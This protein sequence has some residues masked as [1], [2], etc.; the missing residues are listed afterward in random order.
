M[1]EREMWKMLHL[2]YTAPPG[3]QPGLSLGELISAGLNC[4]EDTYDPLLKSDAVLRN[5][6]RFSLSTAASAILRSCVVANRKRQGVDVWVDYP[7]AFVIMP[8]SKD[9][10]NKV[11]EGLIKPALAGADLEYVRGDTSP[12][13]SELT[14]NIWNDL[15]QAG[16]IIADISATNANVFYELGLAHALGKV[17]FIL[18]QKDADVP[19]D[20]GGAHYY[21]YDLNDLEAGMKELRDGLKAYALKNRFAAVKNIYGG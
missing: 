7:K 4:N 21:E 10:S 5:G 18:K 13:A 1:G 16:V 8:F 2:L 14:E 3:Q 17:V 19:A 11:K 12:R 20:F 9:W 15:L 6:D